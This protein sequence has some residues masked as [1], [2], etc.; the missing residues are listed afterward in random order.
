MKHSKFFSWN[1][2]DFIK[3]AVMAA[4]SAGANVVLNIV[5]DSA[6]PSVTELRNAAVVGVCAGIAYL[7]KQLFTNSTGQLA[8]KEN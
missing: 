4:A 3:G 8:K 6:L 7:I 5:N 1:G 2:F